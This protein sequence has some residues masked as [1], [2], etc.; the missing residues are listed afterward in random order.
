MM[1]GLCLADVAGLA[2]LGLRARPLRAVLAGA[3]VA[4]GVATMVAVLGISGSSRAQL[5]AEID[6]LGTNMLTATPN[7][8]LGSQNTALPPT[9]EAMTAR[10]GPVIADAAIGIVSLTVYRNDHI[11]AADTE[12]VSVDAADPNLLATVEGNLSRGT[13]LNAATARYPALVLGAD[14]ATALGVD[15]TGVQLWLDNCWFT[16]V[17]ILRPVTLAPELNRAA[18][19]GFTQASKLTAAPVP[20]TEL[21]VR[22]NPGSTGAVEAVL[23]A[24]VEP[25]SPQSVIITDPTD[26]LTARADASVALQG[27]FLALGA[28]ALLVGGVG[29]ADVMAMSVLERRGEVGLRRALGARRAHIGVQFLAESALLALAGGTTGTVLGGFVTTV[30]AAARHWSAVVPVTDLLLAIAAA[31]TIGA[32]AG[33][34]PALRAS[35]LSP[36]EALR[37][38]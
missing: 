38:V 36:A 1:P 7:P 11:P 29:I 20:P 16:V 21:Y 31:T 24:T 26:A 18:L 37:A 3:G 2:A 15:R 34:Y 6:V 13:F 9:A 5:V 14:A 28:V 22:T 30:Y 17:G 12:S 8:L 27:L 19:I 33:I 10:I 25:S 4:L 32:A 23:A 35:R